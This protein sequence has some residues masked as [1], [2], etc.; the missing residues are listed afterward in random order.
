MSAVTITTTV[1]AQRINKPASQNNGGRFTEAEEGV[2]PTVTNNNCKL[3]RSATTTE[4]LTYEGN[5]ALTHTTRQVDET[6]PSPS[7]DAPPDILKG[8]SQSAARIPVPDQC[9]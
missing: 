2:P 5:V 9:C 6:E 3:Q 7:T 1:N 4:P 8:T